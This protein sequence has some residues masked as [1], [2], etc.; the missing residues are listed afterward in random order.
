[1][2]G[3]Q[4]FFITVFPELGLVSLSWFTYDNELPHEETPSNLGDPGHRWLNALGAINGNQSVMDITIDSGGLFDTTSDIDRVVDG[5]ITVIFDDCNAATVKYDITS[6]TRRGTVP[7]TRV[8]G[9]N[10]LSCETL[11]DQ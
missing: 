7:I 6:I 2:K 9:D 11:K 10:I 3:G 1:V 4:G 8:A 5:T